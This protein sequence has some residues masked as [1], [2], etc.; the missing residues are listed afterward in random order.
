MNK[1]RLRRNIDERSIGGTVHL[2]DAVSSRIIMHVDLD[3]FYAAVEEIRHPEYV[4]KPLV[5]GA[6]SKEGKGRGVVATC[7]YEARKFGIRSGMPISQAWRLNKAAIFVPLDRELYEEV[8]S[9][10]MRILRSY[11]DKFEQVSI[12]EAFLDVSQRAETCEKAKRLAETIRK[13][14]LMREK[15][16]CSIGIG[17]N[18]LVAKI[19]SDFQKPNGLTLVEEEAARRFLAPLPVGRLPSIGRK[20]EERLHAMGVETVAE[21]ASHDIAKSSE[22][23]GVL[24]VTFHR[25]AQGIDG[26]ELVEKW[27]PKSFSREHTF[28]E[29]TSNERIILSTVEELLDDVVEETSEHGFNFKTLT[30]KIRYQDFETHAHSRTISSPTVAAKSP[31][32]IAHELVTDFLKSEKKVRLVG[33]RTSNLDP[34]S[35]QQTLDK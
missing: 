3:A 5:V 10:V 9:R 12:D 11:A 17:P 32:K 35:R 25:M 33:V 4:G 13:E 27:I 19:A 26:S 15:L 16:T 14:L 6:D 31:R 20:T 34:L 24:G 30:V 28:E 21:L 22:E 2:K 18:K 7:N 1:V 23:F 29:D 8:S